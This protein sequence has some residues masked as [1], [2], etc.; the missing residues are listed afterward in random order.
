MTSDVPFKLGE[1][2]FTLLLDLFLFH[3][4]SVLNYIC[5]LHVSS[6]SLK[7]CSL[8]LS[9][10]IVCCTDLQL[11]LLQFSLLEHFNSN[12][13]S[14]LCQPL[15]QAVAQLHKLHGSQLEPFT[16]IPSVARSVYQIMLQQS[17]MILFKFDFSFSN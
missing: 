7:Q 16:Q 9:F 2:V 1:K 5:G 14:I 3:D 13:C 10:S 15:K 12:P 6:H 11:T 8:S 17:Y 4:F